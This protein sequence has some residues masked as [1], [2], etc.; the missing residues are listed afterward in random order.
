MAGRVGFEAKVMLLKPHGQPDFADGDAEVE[1][2]TVCEGLTRG[3]LVAWEFR[4]GSS[5]TEYDTFPGDAGD[6]RALVIEAKR[7][8]GVGVREA[9]DDADV[10][11]PFGIEVGTC[12]GAYQDVMEFRVSPSAGGG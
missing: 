2:G 1:L 3:M 11:P 5:A 4:D 12:S 7:K 9:M 8:R 6:I 10:I